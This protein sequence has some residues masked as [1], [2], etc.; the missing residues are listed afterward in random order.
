MNWIK[1]IISNL[2]Y[3]SRYYGLLGK[4][5]APDEPRLII[6]MYHDFVRHDI[7]LSDP[8]QHGKPSDRHLEAQLKMLK[9]HFRV[10]ALEDAIVEIREKGKL[11]EPTASITLDDGYISSYEIAYPILKRLGL[12]ATIYLPTDWIDGTCSMWWII[13][14]QL[15]SDCN[16]AEIDIHTVDSL[17]GTDLTEKMGQKGDETEKRKLFLETVEAIL[18]D[19]PGTELDDVFAELNKLL[20]NGNK[21]TNREFTPITWDQAAEMSAN[22]IRIGAHTCTHTNMKYLN[23]EA[24]EWEIAESKRIIEERIGHEV[25]GFAYP[26]G[27]DFDAFENITASLK[28]HGF[29]YAVTACFGNND[30]CSDLY[31]LRRITLP[32]TTSAGLL[33]RELAIDYIGDNHEP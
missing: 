16:I 13:L 10:M 19:H 20:R 21:T 6:V 12:T 14:K 1:T 9:K 28:K 31:R 17:L 23:P 4:F 2:L 24:A 22:G 27:F 33:G 3:H 7:R 11:T 15:V 18:R 26:Y 25:T 32:P 30:S 5:A 29:L 8:M